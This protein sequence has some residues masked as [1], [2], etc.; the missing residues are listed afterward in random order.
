MYNNE[1]DTNQYPTN[2]QEQTHMTE[3]AHQTHNHLTKS[4]SNG[5]I[6]LGKM[7]SAGFIG[8]LF[9]TILTIFL[10][11]SQLFT[12]ATNE[13]PNKESVPVN[14]QTNQSEISD[15]IFSSDNASISADINEL[16]ESVVGVVNI[17]KQNIFDQGS[18]AGTGSGIIYKKDGNEAYVVT[19]HHVIE[20][21]KEV[22]VVLNKDQRIEA[23][24][25]G[26]DQ[27]TDLAVLKI[28]GENVDT[29]AKLGSSTEI[30]IGDTVIAIG[31][32]L[33][34]E[35]SNSV[36]K[37]IISGLNRSLNVDTNGDR[38]P[39]W[40]TEVIQTDAAI[41]PGNSGGALVNENGEVIGI[42]SMKIA[43]QSIEGMGFAIPIDQAKNIIKQI[44]ENGEV[45]RPLVGI[46]AVPLN[47][48]PQ[49]YN[50][51]IEVSDDIKSG[52]VV[53]QVENGSPAEEGGLQQ[54]DVIT[55]INDQEVKT[56]IDLKTYI[57]NDVKIN[58]SIELTIYRNGEAQTVEL[59]LDE[60]I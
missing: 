7:L 10:M 36:T 58:E 35:F 60:A 54:Y 57:Y 50:R 28:N 24:I 5:R 46:S 11:S 29:V 2:Q 30:K 6:G 34:L 47:Q 13:Q 21:S 1:H 20:G 14:A 16:S 3:S 52:L 48:V 23:E 4:K 37:G 59:T 26:S 38:Q 49:P 44:E 55:K 32:P 53:A 15:Q 17:Q 18:E 27:L 42:N 41:N 40:V 43:Q 25:V 51:N 9:A 45:K 12:S 56:I 39:D 19:N 33:G 31:N 22:E 8:G